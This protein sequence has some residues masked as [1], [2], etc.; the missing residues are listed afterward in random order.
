MIREG[1]GRNPWGAA[2]VARSA[3][4][5]EPKPVKK[6]KMVFQLCAGG[7]AAAGVAPVSPPSP[8]FSQ[9]VRENDL[10]VP[11]SGI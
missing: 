1:T 7:F 3:K 2:T 11:V 8:A 4:W 5:V 6:A 10:R 9:P